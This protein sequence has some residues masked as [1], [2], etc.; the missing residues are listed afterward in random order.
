MTTPAKSLRLQV[1]DRIVAVLTAITQGADYW[2][3]P[4]IFRR[5]ILENEM[6]G[7]VAYAV[8]PGPGQDPEEINGEHTE[9]FEVLVRGVVRD[10]SDPVSAQE[11]AMADIRKAI[12]IDSRLGTAG[13]L[14]ALTVKVEIG[15]SETDEGEF[16]A[17][18]LGFFEQRIRVEVAGN[19]FADS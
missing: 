11:K 14:G 16:F 18:N 9:R 12:D 19:P 5:A 1:I 15:S 4:Q 2:Y 6:V 13:A 8:F 17:Q 10:A 3:T 7:N